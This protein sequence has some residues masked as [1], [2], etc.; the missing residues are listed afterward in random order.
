MKAYLNIIN[1]LKNLHASH[2]LNDPSAHVCV[3]Q[4]EWT[5]ARDSER[6]I[7]AAGIK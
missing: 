4:C 7:S 6:D 1:N 5:V 3:Y 2:D